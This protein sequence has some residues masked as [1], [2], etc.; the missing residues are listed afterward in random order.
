MLKLLH[1][2]LQPLYE[3]IDMYN[4]SVISP[5]SPCG[6]S[7]DSEPDENCRTDIYNSI[8]NWKSSKSYINEQIRRLRA[9]LFELK[10]MSLVK[11]EYHY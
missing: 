5:T 3:N 10:V 11:T 7:E 9:Q 6:F 8:P 1:S 4:G 2:N